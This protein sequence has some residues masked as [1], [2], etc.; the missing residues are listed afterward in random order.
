MMTT[1]EQIDKQQHYWVICRAELL[2]AVNNNKGRVKKSIEISIL[3][4][5]SPP[6]V[7]KII[8]YFFSIVDHNIWD[9]KREIEKF[10]KISKAGTLGIFYF[11]IF[12][13]VFCSGKSL[14]NVKV[15][16]EG[17]KMLKSPKLTQCYPFAITPLWKF[18]YFFWTLL[19]VCLKHP[20]DH[21]P[22][23][24]NAPLRN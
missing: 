22:M 12:N 7:W 11:L 20:K 18:P 8:F 24:C 15:L 6:K 1:Q 5:T 14:E 23:Q 19:V 16:F 4:L 10:P 13:T 2:S 21:T 17:L 3:S 9:L